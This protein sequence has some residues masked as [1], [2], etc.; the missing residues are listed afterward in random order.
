[1]LEDLPG[2]IPTPTTVDWIEGVSHSNEDMMSSAAEDE[3]ISI[4]IIK[5]HSCERIS[6]CARSLPDLWFTENEWCKS[7]AHIISV[8]IPE[9]L[10]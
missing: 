9:A 5:L 2:G 6:W 7:F 1:M 10:T 4:C 3:A 8:F